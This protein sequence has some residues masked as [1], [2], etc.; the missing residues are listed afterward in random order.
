MALPAGS[1]HLGKADG[2][3]AP[4]F[5]MSFH[6]ADHKAAFR[7]HM[8]E[9]MLVDH[10]TGMGDDIPGYGEVNQIQCLQVV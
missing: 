8:C 4:Q 7:R 6:L 9:F 2:T 5:P 10:D 3:P 1:H